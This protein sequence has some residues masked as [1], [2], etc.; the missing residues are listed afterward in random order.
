MVEV[1][2][3]HS[4]FITAPVKEF[5]ENKEDAYDPSRTWKDWQIRFAQDTGSGLDSE[6]YTLLGGRNGAYPR[7][8]VLDGE[9][10]IRYI[11]PGSA[12]Y[13]ALEAQV[14]ALL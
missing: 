12:T 13:A 4:A 2:A 1:V 11:F 14:E 3:I 9:G 5:I 10:K 7:T 8:L 6:V